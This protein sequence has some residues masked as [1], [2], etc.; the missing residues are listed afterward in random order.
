MPDTDAFVERLFAASIASMETMAVYLGDRLGLYRALHERGPSSASELAAAAG[1]EER[2]A[3]EWLEQ[4]AVAEVLSVDDA[5]AGPDERRY[6]LPAEHA[7][8]LIDPDSGASMAPFVR[9]VA[10]CGVVLPRIAE[11]FRTGGGVPWSAFGADVIEAQGDFNRPWLRADFTRTYLPAVDDVHQRLLAGGRLADIACGVGWAAI[12]VA[13]EYERA[14][15]VGLDPDPSSIEIARGL[16]R[17]EGL[18]E[19]ARFEV[20]DCTEPLPGGPFDAAV[21]VESL[22]DVAR[23]VEILRRVRASLTDGGSLIVADERTAERF[24]APGDDL[25]RLFYAFSLVCCLPAGMSERPTAATGTVIRPET[26]ERYASE[27]G[28]SSCEVIDAIDHPLLRFYR[29]A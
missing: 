21:M 20:H 29:L 18:H 23:P 3:R 5:S 11:A 8:A 27:A 1:V 7:E 19:R 16:A 13:R 17:D 14:S 25:E 24:T 15:V 9:F 6:S 2:Y 22:H 4:Q 12:A 26:V 10:G 28:F